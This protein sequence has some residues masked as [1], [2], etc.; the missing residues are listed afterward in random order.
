M[1][2]HPNNEATQKTPTQQNW[3]FVSQAFEHAITL[4]FSP[5][6]SLYW[7]GGYSV[8]SVAVELQGRCGTR[9]HADSIG[10][11][12]IAGVVCEES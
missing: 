8:V 6:F 12:L 1:T 3:T 4:P 5:Q 9:V 11:I 10:W 7:G 2:A